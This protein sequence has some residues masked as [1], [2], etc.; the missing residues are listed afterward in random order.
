MDDLKQKQQLTSDWFLN[1]RNR[2]C[3]EF[4]KI[5]QEYIESNQNPINLGIK[6]NNIKFKKKSWKRDAGGGGKTATLKGNVFEKV[7]I[8]ISTV[9]GKLSPEFSQQIPGTEKDPSFWASGISLVAHMQSPLV[10]A[11]HFNT[12]FICTNKNW[13]GGGS[14]L[15]PIFKV[16]T[17]TQDFHQSFKNTCDKHNPNYYPKFKKWCDEYFYIKHRKQTRGVG[18]IFYDYLNSNNF[19]QDFNFTKDIGLTFLDIFPRLVKKNMFKKW[20]NKQREQQLIKR[21]LYTEFNLIYDRGTKFGLMTDGNVEAILMSL[22]PIAKW[23]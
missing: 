14:D 4:E 15:N 16:K 8:N 13:F 5:E 18:G 2:I 12:R 6:S 21:G 9:F 3:T 22:P 20:N 1:L 23:N 11:V 10:P 7:G 17:D 19:T